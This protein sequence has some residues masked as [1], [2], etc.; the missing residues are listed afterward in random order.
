MLSDHEPS[1]RKDNQVARREQ[2]RFRIDDL[3]YDIP[4]TAQHIMA[5]INDGEAEAIADTLG[6]REPHGEAD[7]L[8]EFLSAHSLKN[9]RKAARDPIG[10]FAGQQP[11]MKHRLERQV[12]V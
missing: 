12:H 5:V 1:C 2:R 10:F 4:K 6:D 9:V 8:N 7:N 3:R 11:L